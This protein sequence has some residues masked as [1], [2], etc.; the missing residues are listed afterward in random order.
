MDGTTVNLNVFT[1]RKIPSTTAGTQTM[2]AAASHFTDMHL[3]I[4]L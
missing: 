1:K 2:A 3:E 4:T